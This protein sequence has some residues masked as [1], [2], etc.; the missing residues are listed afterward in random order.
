MVQSLV[1][2]LVYTLELNFFSENNILVPT[3]EML[4]EVINVHHF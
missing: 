1:Q 4:R 2:D 3:L